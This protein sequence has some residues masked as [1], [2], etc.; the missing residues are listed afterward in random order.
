M[1]H[2][3]TEIIDYLLEQRNDDGWPATTEVDLAMQEL[4]AHCTGNPQKGHLMRALNTISQEGI[5]REDFD[6]ILAGIARSPDQSEKWPEWEVF[7]P[8]QVELAG[9][10]PTSPSLTIHGTTF[11]F[12][13]IDEVKQRLP[14]DPTDSRELTLAVRSSDLGPVPETY[15]VA[16]ETAASWRN[17][18]R[19]LGPSFDVFKGFIEFQ[20]KFGSRRIG[21]DAPRA[22]FPHP[23]WYVAYDGDETANGSTFLVDDHEIRRPIELDS[24]HL[25]VLRTKSAFLS[26][27]PSS[28]STDSLIADALRLYSQAMDERFRD[29]CFLGLWQTLETV[30]LSGDVRGDTRKICSRIAWHGSRVGLPGSG[31]RYRL[32]ELAN[33]RNDVVHRGIQDVTDYDINVLKIIVEVALGWLQNVRNDLP[34]EKHLSTYYQ[35]RST[36]SADLKKRRA[37]LKRVEETI[38]FIAAER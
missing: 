31:F 5:S 9:D 21:G 12:R 19:Q 28:K 25:S 6:K 35:Y 18:W 30:A 1:S 26:S 2:E 15:V 36:S 27:K 11:T 8:A 38:S 16:K 34:T 23:K 37:D 14:F 32:K 10:L 29:K 22:S 7:L 3:F 33:K 24:S 13:G 20:H 4:M 17:V